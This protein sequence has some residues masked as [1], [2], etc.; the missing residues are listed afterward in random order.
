MGDL[1]RLER[2]EQ[3]GA[4]RLVGWKEEK[5]DRDLGRLQARTLCTPPFL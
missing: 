3:R 5:I 1:K 4:I 2:G